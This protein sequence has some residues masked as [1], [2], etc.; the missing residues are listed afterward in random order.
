MFIILNSHIIFDYCYNNIMLFSRRKNIEDIIVEELISNPYQTGPK[1]VEKTSIIRK[2]STPKQSVYAALKIL[3]KEEIVVKTG[4]N[5]FV[6]KL[7]KEKVLDAL[8][9]SSDGEKDPI[10][11]LKDGDFINYKFP[12]L[13]VCDKYWAHLFKI[14]TEQLPSGENIFVWNPHEWFVIGRSKEEQQVFEKLKK[15]NVTA[16]YSINGKT[17]LDKEFKRKFSSTHLRINIGNNSFHKNNYYVNVFGDYI[18]EVIIDGEL[19]EKIEDFYIKYQ[20]LS[21]AR[22]QIFEN[23]VSQRFTIKMKLSRK[24]NKAEKIRRK[25]SKDF[26]IPKQKTR[27]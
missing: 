5:Y 1:L 10:F 6:S 13:L 8:M 22:I 7:W 21:F 11:D 2:E 9:S 3:M 12:S 19:A 17:N 15:E 14:L 18:I 25:L 20:E 26:Y 27:E 4:I 23:L 24:K 16:F